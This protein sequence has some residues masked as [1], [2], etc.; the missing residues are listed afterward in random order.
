ML[1]DIMAGG[2][3]KIPLEEGYEIAL[4]ISDALYIV[5]LILDDKINNWR[6]SAV[7]SPIQPTCAVSLQETM[8]KY[9]ALSLRVRTYH[10]LHL[11]FLNFLTALMGNNNFKWINRGIKMIDIFMNQCCV[12]PLLE[13]NNKLWTDAYQKLSANNKFK[14]VF[15][16]DSSSKNGRCRGDG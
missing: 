16:K 14:N 7:N 4:K 2:S 5:I 3:A 13:W 15:W 10:D 6:D 1:K 12:E 8:K 9:L 11:K